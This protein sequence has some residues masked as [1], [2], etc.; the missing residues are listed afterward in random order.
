MHTAWF[1]NKKQTQSQAF[2]GTLKVK[3][4]LKN[5]K[6]IVLKCYCM[7]FQEWLLL[8]FWKKNFVFFGT[9]RA[10]SNFERDGR[11]RVQLTSQMWAAM[12]HEAQSRSFP[13]R[14]N[15][16]STSIVQCLFTHSI[17]FI[18]SVEIHRG[19][20]KSGGMTLQNGCES[21]TEV[22]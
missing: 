7:S 9:R 18:F 15:Y 14:G 21:N 11:S 17:F 4:F 8:F 20:H 5:K 16:Q 3:G 13:G 22:I 1:R 12:L 10:A 19:V 2:A 6:N